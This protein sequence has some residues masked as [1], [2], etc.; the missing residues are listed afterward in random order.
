MGISVREQHSDVA[1]EILNCKNINVNAIAGNLGTSLHI[2]VVYQLI[3]V[4]KKL[5]QKGADPNL[6]DA[7]ASTPLHKVIEIYTKNE[8][9]SFETIQ[10]LLKYGANPNLMNKNRKTPL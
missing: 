5:L 2:A 4:V 3:N 7:I 1:L 8:D 9:I 6:T 10:L